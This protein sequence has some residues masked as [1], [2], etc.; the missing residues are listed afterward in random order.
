MQ[1]EDVDLLAPVICCIEL[2]AEHSECR[3]QLGALGAIPL[4]L[5]LLGCAAPHIALPIR[6]SLH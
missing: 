3:A 1:H 4:L 6:L 5:S 2:L